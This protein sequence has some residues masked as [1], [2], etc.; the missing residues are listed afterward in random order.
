MPD[1]LSIWKFH[2]LQLALFGVAF[3]NTPVTIIFQFLLALFFALPGRLPRE[4]P[5]ERKVEG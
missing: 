5:Q 1:N 4:L 2:Y 3:I